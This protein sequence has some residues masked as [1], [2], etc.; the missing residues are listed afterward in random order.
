MSLTFKELAGSPVETYQPE[1][2]K[3]ER[4]LLCAYE[5]R[6]AVGRGPAGRRTSSATSRRY[7]IRVGRAW[8]PRKCG[9]EPFEKRAGPTR[10]RSAD[11]TAD[12]N[13]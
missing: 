1:G 2:M 12:L 3:A 10:E 4:R 9:W 6:R 11:L 8:W 5:D 13:G 7:P